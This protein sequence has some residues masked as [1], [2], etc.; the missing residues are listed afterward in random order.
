MDNTLTSGY[1]AKCKLEQFS[2]S[3]KCIYCNSKLH[4]SAKAYRLKL[5]NVN[6][7]TRLF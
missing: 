2:T 5:H 3:G 1:C 6:P 7:M 4:K